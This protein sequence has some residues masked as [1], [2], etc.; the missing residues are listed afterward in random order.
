MYSFTSTEAIRT[1]AHDGHLDF[2]IVPELL[3]SAGRGSGRSVAGIYL[4]P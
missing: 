4:A 3:N 2:H 1:G